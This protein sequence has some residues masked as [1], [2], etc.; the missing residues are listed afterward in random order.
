MRVKLFAGIALILTL[1]AVITNTVIIERNV[2]EIL[3][4][5]D[6]LE[7]NATGT[8][9]YAKSIREDFLDKLT[10]ISLTVNH[11]DLTNIETGFAELIGYLEVEDYDGAHVT[12][13]RLVDSLEHLWRLSGFNIDAII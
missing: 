11:D 9:D 12:K 4:R 8:L 1:G 10:Y 13:S 2:S 3:R 6:E 5:V 7:V